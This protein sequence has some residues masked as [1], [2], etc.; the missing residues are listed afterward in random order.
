MGAG[1]RAGTGA[2]YDTPLVIHASCV[3]YDNRAVLIRGASG[4]GKSSLALQLMALGAGLVADD[5][6]CLA[7]EDHDGQTRLMASVPDALRGRIE[8]RGLGI[9]NANPVGPC[10][11]ALTVDLDQT[12]TQRLPDLRHCEILSVS[13]PLLHMVDS[14][15]FP[16][17]ILQ[18]LKAGRSA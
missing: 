8:A 3:A 14:S 18:Y 2:P 11:V 17:A 7:V 6:T 5:R 12:E 4:R 1:Q 16:A 15:A 13:V 10:P 9:L